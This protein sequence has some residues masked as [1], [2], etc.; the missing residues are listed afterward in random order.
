MR[1]KYRLKK[2]NNSPFT[3]G[4]ITEKVIGGFNAPLWQGIVHGA[5]DLKINL[6]TFAINEST[7]RQE[8]QK[9]VNDIY[10]LIGPHNIEGL[11]INYGILSIFGSK[12]RITDLIQS[13][14]PMPIISIA[15]P[16]D[17]EHF[18]CISADNYNG[19][20]EIVN[21]LVNTHGKQRIAFIR[22][23]KNHP[24]EEERF[25]AYEDALVSNGIQ[26]D[27]VL[28]TSHLNWSGIVSAKRAL[29]LF[30]EKNKDGFDALIGANDTLALIAMDILGRNNIRIPDDIAV[31]GFDNIDASYIS[32]PRLTTVQNATFEMGK[33]AV[34]TIIALLKG[35]IVAETTTIP[36]RL[37][38][39]QSCC[40][41]S[42]DVTYRS[43][44]FE[45]LEHVIIER[46][47]SGKK[48]YFELLIDEF[49]K[50]VV[51]LVQDI[52]IDQ[53]MSVIESLLE[54]MKTDII[55]EKSGT[56][57]PL[58]SDIIQKESIRG[59]ISL[60]QKIFRLLHDFLTHHCPL[61]DFLLRAQDLLL[62]A[63]YCIENRFM[64]E[65]HYQKQYLSALTND[66][67]I[68]KFE[69]ESI[70]TYKDLIAN[71]DAQVRTAG[72][73][74]AFLFMYN[75]AGVPSSECKL[76]YSL[77]DISKERPGK[78]KN[79][80]HSH[81]IISPDILPL[82]DRFSLLVQPL[83]SAE[84]AF[85]FIVFEVSS[86]EGYLYFDICSHLNNSL[87]VLLS[88][89][90]QQ[91]IMNGMINA[92]IHAVES[93]DPY[94]AGHLKNVAELATAIALEMGYSD[95]AVEGIFMAASI[96]DI[97]RI[98][99]PAEILCK[100]SKLTEIEYNIVKTHAQIGFE[101]LEEISFPWPIAEIIHQHHERLDGSGYPRGLTGGD[102]LPEA[103]ILAV[104][105]VIEAMSS[106]RP[107][108]PP[109]SIDE[110]LEEIINNKGTLYDQAV[111]DVCVRLFREEGFQ[112]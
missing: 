8:K 96:H 59:N 104:A 74:R 111:V 23:P 4:F 105:D 88:V 41:S 91:K 78:T 21:H 45:D 98:S 32:T 81:S 22:G 30:I 11:I 28:V 71:I 48:E 33:K 51:Q 40:P 67:S 102:I 43:S 34:E 50:R 110:A 16:V 73:K 17:G 100:P 47:L 1:K 3:I 63:R 9:F 112:F 31:C 70:S 42:P 53:Y 38:I 12:K 103:R 72:I 66:M 49:T 64:Q 62:E 109:F 93:R 35:E 20:F 26:V 57:L 15:V 5:E 99:V 89:Y 75:E 55:E 46:K 68:I 2:W 56:F 77:T 86:H 106:Y 107:Y 54:A 101:I 25:R 65:Y 39:R 92:L 29:S 44:Q 58:L 87:R 69:M 90:K 7:I 19:M 76:I 10:P 36:S 108:R 27:P 82:A 83:R 60:Y 95:D 80:I 84:D 6:I 79:G 24:E 37:I 18:P 14:K 94:T 52:N 61:S 85:G 97:G 13:L